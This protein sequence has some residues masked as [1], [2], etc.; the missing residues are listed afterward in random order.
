MDEANRVAETRVKSAVQEAEQALNARQAA[1]RTEVYELA[2]AEAVEDVQRSYKQSMAHDYKRAD[3]RADDATRR[4]EQCL[5]QRRAALQSQFDA[6]VGSAMRAARKQAAHDVAD[7]MRDA[8]DA[9]SMATGLVM[10]YA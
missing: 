4:A 10:M 2:R 5:G 8:D 6:K 7:A 1:A 3:A 9:V